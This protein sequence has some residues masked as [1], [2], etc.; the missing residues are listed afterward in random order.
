VGRKPER[1]IG[2]AT[3]RKRAAY[4]S[5][6]QRFPRV[7]GGIPISVEYRVRTHKPVADDGGDADCGEEV[8]CI[9]VVA[10]RNA[11]EVFERQM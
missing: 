3:R 2:C 8:H 6:R 9:S 7:I 10:G 11:P 4:T 1:L 5:S